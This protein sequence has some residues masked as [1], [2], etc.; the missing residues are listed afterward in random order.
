L[1]LGQLRMPC[2]ELPELLYIQVGARSKKGMLEILII[3]DSRDDLLLVERTIRQAGFQNAV[4]CF[5]IRRS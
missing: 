3:D 5:K 1:E 4:H 2:K